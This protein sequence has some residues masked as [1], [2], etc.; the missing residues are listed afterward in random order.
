MEI[1]KL[2]QKTE[3]FEKLAQSNNPNDP[4]YTSNLLEELSKKLT[5]LQSDLKEKT[6]NWTKGLSSNWQEDDKNLY[7][8]SSGPEYAAIQKMMTSNPKQIS[9]FKEQ[10]FNAL[11][12]AHKAT[13]IKAYFE[14]KK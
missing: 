4:N 12:E 9:D 3:L 11:N 2:L 10:Q 14:L 13:I 7:H 8:F 6:N 1:D 5:F